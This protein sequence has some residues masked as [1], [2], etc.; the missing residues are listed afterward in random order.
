MIK[1]KKHS[2]MKRMIVITMAALLS[3]LLTSL[4]CSAQDPVQSKDSKGV[5]EAFQD[6]FWATRE[7]KRID[8]AVSSDVYEFDILR[9]DA[10]GSGTIRFEDDS[11]LEVG[12]NSEI[13]VK[14]VVFS[15]EQNR[16]DVGVIQG[17]AR[18][19][20]G[21]I[22]KR[23]PEGFKVTT[24]RSTIGIRGTDLLVSL[25]LATGVETVMVNDIS[26][27]HSVSVADKVLGTIANI[28]QRGISYSVDPATNSISINGRSLIELGASLIGVSVTTLDGIVYNGYDGAAG[29]E[30]I[31][32]RILKE[33]SE[34]IYDGASKS[35]KNQDGGNRQQR[36]EPQ[37]PKPKRPEPK[38]QQ[39]PN[40]PRLP[41]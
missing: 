10:S 27:S 12:N 8:L 32:E 4:A 9:T 6:S 40:L 13:D 18:V 29:A 35:G 16:F 14:E 26:E 17:A 11:I 37:K 24:P 19:I 30:K 25:D 1:L 20:T 31:P 21:A 5:V 34:A 15:D 22:V 23:N 39:R 33:L 3:F 28:T 36:P 38:R 41:R 7:E 2:A